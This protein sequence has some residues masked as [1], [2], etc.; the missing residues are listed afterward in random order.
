[1]NHFHQAPLPLSL[2]PMKAQGSLFGVLTLS[3]ILLAGCAA[4]PPPAP[5]GPRWD[6][7]PTENIGAPAAAH[8]Y[9]LW[10]GSSLPAPETFQEILS[11]ATLPV[12]THGGGARRRILFDGSRCMLNAITTAPEQEELAAQGSCSAELQPQIGTERYALSCTGDEQLNVF[13]AAQNLASTLSD[14]FQGVA[15][16]RGRGVCERAP[17]LTQFRPSE[18]IS[19]RSAPLGGGEQALYTVGL[20]AFG[21]PEL[22]IAPV[23]EARVEVG[24][25]VL[26]TFATQ[27]LTVEA[28]RAGQRLEGRAA[29]AI[30]V[31]RELYEAQRPHSAWGAWRPVEKSLFMV[32]PEAEAGDAPAQRQFVLRMTLP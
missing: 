7:L 30:L 22:V 13:V 5:P 25:G 6:A 31:T 1:M 12:S 4:P 24:K 18:T 21:Q 2:T 20:N 10:L 28:L 26:L 27:A 14:K 9:W 11:A 16:H 8:S 29:T 32:S 19:V 15:F 17:R 3:I 23:P